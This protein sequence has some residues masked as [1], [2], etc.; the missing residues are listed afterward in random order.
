M[1]ICSGAS[2]RDHLARKMRLRRR[3]DCSQDDQAKQVLKGM[4]DV[5]QEKKN[6]EVRKDKNY[7]HNSADFQ[8]IHQEI[9]QNLDFAGER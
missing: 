2:P 7:K 3:K 5:V 4:S 1:C 9:L 6:L 8:F